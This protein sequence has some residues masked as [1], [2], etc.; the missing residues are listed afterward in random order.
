MDGAAGCLH[1]ISPDN[2]PL[3]PVTTFDQ[4]VRFDL[5]YKLQ[6]GRLIKRSNETDTLKRS[7]ECHAV[8]QRV[9]RPSGSLIQL[10]YRVIGIQG[11]QQRDS[12]PSC[13]F[14]IG[15][16]ATMENIETAVG[17]NQWPLGGVDPPLQRFGVEDDFMGAVQPR[18]RPADT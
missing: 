5:A 4:V 3:T 13:F 6:R 2:F 16:V 1:D 7:D 17:K 10:A 12:Q 15:D 14:K 9:D 11:H 18:M 8:F